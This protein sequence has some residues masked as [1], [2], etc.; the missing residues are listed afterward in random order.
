[1]L[2]HL[3]EEVLHPRGPGGLNAGTAAV[4]RIAIAPADLAERRRRRDDEVHDLVDLLM[5]HAAPD[6][7]PAAT[8]AIAESVAL[9]S[10]GDRHLWEDLG[11]PS[12][13]ALGALM[14]AHFPSLAAAN[15]GMRWKKYLYRRLCEREQVLI[16]RSPSCDTCDERAV[17]FAPEGPGGR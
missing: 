1:M 7:D 3:P 10:L 16:C 8:R 14:H 4:V 11:L 13:A 15:G 5:A 12:R 9:A 2:A 6:R 17:C